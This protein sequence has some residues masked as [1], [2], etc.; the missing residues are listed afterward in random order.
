MWK[1]SYLKD[2]ILFVFLTLSAIG[3]INIPG[4]VDQLIKGRP[5]WYYLLI[6]ILL[7][8]ILSIIF[9]T[10]IETKLSTKPGGVIFLILSVVLLIVILSRPPTEQE[11][12]T[13]LINSEAQWTLH[14]NIDKIMT[15]FADGA[16]IANAHGE[17]WNGSERIRQRYEWIFTNQDFV[18]LRHVD[19]KV[20]IKEDDAL[21]TCSTEGLYIDEK[22]A[23]NS[24]WGGKDSERWILKQ[25]N[26][27]WKVI[28]FV[29]NLS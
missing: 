12:I 1:K 25:I 20:A 17:T 6:L 5:L 13:Q 14:G 24:I 16:Y 27:S 8:I 28:T 10:F 3:I 18:Y 11:K 23:E 4:I 22:G 21:V 7:I 19:I 2:L 29:Y 26:G 9:F 15:I